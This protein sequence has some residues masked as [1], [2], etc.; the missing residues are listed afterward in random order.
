MS[1]G[2][3][4]ASIVGAAEVT[5]APVILLRDP[6]RSVVFSGKAPR[7]PFVMPAATRA[8]ASE[9]ASGRT[10]AGRTEAFEQ[11]QDMERNGSDVASAAASLPRVVATLTGATSDGLSNGSTDGSCTRELA[12]DFLCYRCGELLFQPVY[13]GGSLVYRR[14]DE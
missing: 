8:E 5:D 4:A 9:A 2:L 1:I 3:A 14:V 11:P 13:Y 12:G 6:G 7:V 10:A